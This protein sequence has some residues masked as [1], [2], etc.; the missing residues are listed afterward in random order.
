M[1]HWLGIANGVY[2]LV[3]IFVVGF[4][5][6]TFQ[7][8]VFNFL[9]S[10]IKSNFEFSYPLLAASIIIIGYAITFLDLHNKFDRLIFGIRK[11]TADYI[12]NQ[13][14]VEL[15]K[16]CIKKRISVPNEFNFFRIFYYFVGKSD[17]EWRFQTNRA[18]YYWTIYYLVMNLIVL[19]LFGIIIFILSLLIGNNVSSITGIGIILFFL[20]MICGLSVTARYGMAKKLTIEIPKPQ[21]DNIIYNHHDELEGL[22][23]KQIKHST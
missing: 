21:L 13:L 1:K 18:F 16:Y 20:L 3:I 23:E 17:D 9:N 8:Y 10:L 15:Q 4:T 11:D 5:T 12:T 6:E 14:N 19:S 2:F 22:F 7:T